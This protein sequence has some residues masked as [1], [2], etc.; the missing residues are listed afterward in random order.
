MDKNIILYLGCQVVEL[1]SVLSLSCA[2][3]HYGM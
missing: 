3:L 2:K 1:M